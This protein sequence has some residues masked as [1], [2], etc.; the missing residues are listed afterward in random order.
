MAT[1]KIVLRKKKNK[2]GTYPLAIRI[3]Q[4]RKTSFIHLGKHLKVDEWDPLAQRVKKSH[5]S[6]TRLNNFLI[7]K[8]AE[9]NNNSL[10]LETKKTHVTAKSVSQSIKPKTKGTLFAQ[11]DL[12]LERLK[13]DGKYN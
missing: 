6:A 3:T 7:T 9:A 11:A 4:D 13:Q 12:Y 2:D 5:A 8:L 10:E 1:I